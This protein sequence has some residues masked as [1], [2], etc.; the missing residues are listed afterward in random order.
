MNTLNIINPNAAGIDVGSEF[1]YVCVPEGNKEPRVRKFACF[2]N[3]LNKL[4][5]WLIECNIKTVTMES[6][7]VFWVPLYEILTAHGFEVVLANAKYVKNVPGRK[8]DVQDCQ[9]LQQLHS[10][11]LLQG[12]FLPD[13]LISVLRGYMRQRDNLV[14]GAT[15]HIQR[16]QKAL[17]QMNIQ[18]HKVIS[19]I[20]GETGLRIIRAI[21]DGERNPLKLASLCGARIRNDEATIAQALVGNYREDH[22][23]SLQQEYNLYLEYQTKVAECD[24]KILEHYANFESKVEASQMEGGNAKSKNNPKFNLRDELHRI[25]GVDFTQVP[26]LDVLSI[27]TIISEVGLNSSKWPSEKHF[28]SWLG[29]SPANKITGGK[30]YSTKTRKVNNRASIVFRTCAVGLGRSKTALG[31]F[32]RRIKSKA[33]APKAITAT[34]RKLACLFYN[35]LKHGNA[36]IEK[37]MEEYENKYKDRVIKNLEKR[38]QELGFN[39]IKVA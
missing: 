9:W 20:T 37:G 24:K 15:I 14:K 3:E 33:G 2:T 35:L 4:A 28:A 19:D 34:A 21:L 23:F 12:S 10:Y 18:L 38:A 29:L 27:Q 7:G 1:H 11:G 5:G 32:Y 6:T 36:Y 39:L 13:E 31:A 8:T 16:M 22:L 17:T 25:T 30:V 26:G